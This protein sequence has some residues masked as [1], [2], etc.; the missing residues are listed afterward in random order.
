MPVMRLVRVSGGKLR[1]RFALDQS[2][3]RR[4]RTMRTGIVRRLL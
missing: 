4:E 2:S 1:A 3:T